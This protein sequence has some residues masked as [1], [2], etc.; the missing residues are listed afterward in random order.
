MTALPEVGL[1]HA[2]QV[3]VEGPGG[4]VAAPVVI[5]SI[6]VHKEVP[7]QHGESRRPRTLSHTILLVDRIKIV[8]ESSELGLQWN[9]ENLRV[10]TK[11]LPGVIYTPHTQTH[12]HS[13][14]LM[15]THTPKYIL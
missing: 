11:I 6:R 8:R 10:K 12:K 7:A 15:Y 2:V 3:L 13:Y 5:L 4:E 14:T 9:P 1:Q